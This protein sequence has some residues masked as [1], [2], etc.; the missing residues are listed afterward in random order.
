MSPV[1]AVTQL[2]AEALDPLKDEMAG[3][4]ITATIDART[5]RLNGDVECSITFR[6]PRA[7]AERLASESV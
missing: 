3:L 4:G 6:V 7:T 5:D 1:T 2:L